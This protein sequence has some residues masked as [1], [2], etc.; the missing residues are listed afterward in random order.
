MVKTFFA[1]LLLNLS[2][3][4]PGQAQTTA[5][6][7]GGWP[8]RPVKLIV[9]SGAGSAT[10]IV[11]RVIGDALSKIYGQ[12]FVIDNKAG[13]NGLIG[14]D[15][16]AKAAPDGYTLLFTYAAA[17]VVNPSMIEKMPYDAEKSFAPIAQ[18][19]AGGNLLVVPPS[20]PVKDLKEFLAYV[21]SK[22]KDSLTYGSWGNGSG[23]HLSMEALKQQTGLGIRH[24][25]Y[26]SSA[27][28]TADVLGG[29]IDMAFAAAVLAIP[30]VNGGKLKALAVS[31]NYRVPQLPEVKTMTEQGVKF[32]LDAWY[33]MLAPA[34]TPPVI[35]SSINQEIMKMITT[36]EIAAKWRATLGFSELPVK[37]PEQFAETIRNDIKGW[38]A[39][40]KAGNIK[41]D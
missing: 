31:G 14:T 3:W 13:A 8:S 21:K 34:G 22:P 26:K 10:D 12:P 25:P 41:A 38:G 32:D 19:G 39:I 37:T 33:A 16:V 36:P 27:A 17:H 30:M 2:L 4:G 40:V 23:G 6:N 24:I 28:S 29:Q 7:L 20:T 9:T 15:A 5:P 18:I 11:A 1:A 35:V